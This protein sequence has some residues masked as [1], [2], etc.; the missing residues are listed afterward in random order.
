[1]HGRLLLSAF[2][3]VSL[4]VSACGS[5]IHRFHL[6]RN[7]PLPGPAGKIPLEEPRYLIGND[8][9]VTAAL[10]GD[11][12]EARSLWE[13]MPS[14][15]ARLNNIGLA[16]RLTGAPQSQV[17]ETLAMALASCPSNEEIRWNYR[18]ELVAD[19]GSPPKLR[20]ME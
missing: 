11:W 14:N 16:L 6:R 19:G 2:A 1:M 3:I 9:G 20:K 18:S 12:K 7:L 17:V 8:P 5:E 13:N 4:L 10:K 15:C